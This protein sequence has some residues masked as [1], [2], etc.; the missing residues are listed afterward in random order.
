MFCDTNTSLSSNQT[1]NTN[2]SKPFER[3][4]TLPSSSSSS[5]NPLNTSLSPPY[6]LLPPSSGIYLGTYTLYQTTTSS[7]PDL[8]F[9]LIPTNQKP[10]K[11]SVARRM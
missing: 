9:T 6:Y 7:N 8:L 2:L 4:I 5:S 1:P 10:T 3:S 11:P